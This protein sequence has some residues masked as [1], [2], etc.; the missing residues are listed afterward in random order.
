MQR[1]NYT[2]SGAITSVCLSVCQQHHAKNTQPIHTKF[3]GGMGPGPERNQMKSGSD[4][5]K[6]ADMTNDSSL[7]SDYFLF[8]FAITGARQMCRAVN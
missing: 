8:P 4:P 6:E 5:V 7:L 2:V 1:D 3:S